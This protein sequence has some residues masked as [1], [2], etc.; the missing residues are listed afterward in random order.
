MLSIIFAIVVALLHAYF[1]VLE[2]VLWQKPRGLKTFGNTPERAKVMS[3]MAFNQGLYNLFL[4]AG[5]V[6]SVLLPMPTAMAFRYFFF[7]CVIAAGSV[8]GLTVSKRIF[9]FQAVP[10]IIGLVLTFL[11]L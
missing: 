1:A 10:A 9:F 11:A 8:G 7:A 4:S 5:L 3:V 2:M 6:A